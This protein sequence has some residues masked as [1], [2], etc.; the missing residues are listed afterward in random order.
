MSASAPEND[1]CHNKERQKKPDV[2]LA[3]SIH[4]K[5][6]NNVAGPS[7]TTANS[8]T[9]SPSTSIS[10]IS[11]AAMTD[12]HNNQRGKTPQNKKR[13]VLLDFCS[14]PSTENFSLRCC[15]PSHAAPKLT[16]MISTKNKVKKEK[17]C[18]RNYCPSSK[19]SSC[20]TT[21]K[22][23]K[24]KT[25]YIDFFSPQID[26]TPTTL[27]MP[28]SKDNHR[29]FIFQ[30]GRYAT[31]NS[32]SWRQFLEIIPEETDV[33]L[34]ALQMIKKIW[35]SQIIPSA[36]SAPAPSSLKGILEKEKNK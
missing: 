4:S 24:K 10:K 30:R 8:F 18:R 34:Q 2:C 16:N 35:V 31:F 26:K 3:H 9:G 20:S 32:N 22:K 12:M 13:T 27:N 6:S 14:T 25:K 11:A 17:K 28:F 23:G 19:Q 36:N 15:K 33:E 7:S 21:K 5:G 1:P 29:Q